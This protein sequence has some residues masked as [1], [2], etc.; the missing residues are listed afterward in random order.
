MSDRPID[1]VD[2]AVELLDLARADLD[3]GSADTALDRAT[4]ARQLLE[5]ACGPDHPDVANAFLAI[6]D[7]HESVEDYP[8]AEAAYRRALAILE[9][10]T[11]LLASDVDLARLTV[12]ARTAVGTTQRIRG[13][14]E[15]AHATLSSAVEL[16]VNVLDGDDADTVW[17]LN[18]LG[19]VCK[20]SGRF[21]EGVEH[22]QR[23]L[24]IAERITGPDPAE[25]A[26][27]WHNIGGRAF[28]S[29]DH[30]AA[31]DPT[32]RAVTIHEAVLGPDHPT[33][34]ADVAALAAILDRLGRR[35]EAAVLNERALSILEA[36]PGTGYDLA[37]LHNN[38]GVAAAARGDR[39]AAAEHYRHSLALKEQLLGFD[40]SDV[41]MTLHNMG[42]LALDDDDSGLA[43]GHLDRALAI[44][45]A[46][47]GPGHPRTGCCRDLLA[48]ADRRTTGRARSHPGG[49]VG[50]S[51]PGGGPVMKR[52]E[53]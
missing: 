23:A 24:G 20:Y 51:A 36:N 41:A 38:I 46:T 37:V 7:A 25:T 22:Y 27:I 1:P 47:L 10:F 15:G 2:V 21:S 29:G 3:A 52:V 42:A 40:H 34:A 26:T 30:R 17:A 35:D 6:G 31:L 18:A 50:R 33:V 5:A 4:R 43:T 14:L 49:T 16:A 28:D 9:R 53:S 48:E 13:D 19:I 11:D 44:F 12:Q 32:Q 45:G 39:T 8:A